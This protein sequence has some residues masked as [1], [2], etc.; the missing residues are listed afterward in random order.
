MAIRVP[1]RSRPRKWGASRI[2]GWPPSTRALQAL[3]AVDAHQLA[4]AL[5]GGKPRQPPF[6]QAAPGQG[7]VLLRPAR[8]RSAS[9]FSGKHRRRL[10]STTL[11]AARD[12]PVQ[13][14]AQAA[15]D[16]G[17]DAIGAASG[18]ATAGQR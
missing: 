1:P 17:L 18:A 2:T 4:E 7:E 16:G 3:L 8:V 10:V 6:D 5:G 14:L 15:A 11:R 13:Q 12:Q 9:D